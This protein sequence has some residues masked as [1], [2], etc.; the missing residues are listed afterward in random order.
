MYMD[1]CL[2]G[3]FKVFFFFFANC[4]E[5]TR[6][7]CLLSRRISGDLCIEYTFDICIFCMNACLWK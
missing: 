5:V 3:I 6:I 1:V 2:L 7:R 4:I